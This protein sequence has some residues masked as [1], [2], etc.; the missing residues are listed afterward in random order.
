MEQKQNLRHAYTKYASAKL[1]EGEEKEGAAHLALW[2]LLSSPPQPGCDA[3]SCA[4]PAC[5]AARDWAERRAGGGA[6]AAASWGSVEASV[7]AGLGGTLTQKTHTHTT[8]QRQAKCA[9]GGTN[10]NHQGEILSLWYLMQDS[11]THQETAARWLGCLW[12]WV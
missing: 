7:H 4:F 3:G 2:R 1:N 9:S 8:L 10:P 6:A 12:A 11:E 5:R